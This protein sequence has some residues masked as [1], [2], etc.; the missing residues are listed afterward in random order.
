MYCIC[1]KDYE[2]VDHLILQE[3]RDREVP[4]NRCTHCTRC[5]AWNT[6][7]GFVCS[8]EVAGDEVL[9]GFPGGVLELE[10][11]DLAVLFQG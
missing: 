2:T 9:S 7:A 6:C 5:A 3:I 1:L 10:F 8:E 11:D 4:S